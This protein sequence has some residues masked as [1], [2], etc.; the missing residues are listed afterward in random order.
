MYNKFRS[1]IIRNGDLLAWKNDGTVL[2]NLVS[3]ITKG[4]YTHVGIAWTLHNRAYVLDAFW[5]GGVRLRALEDNLPVDIIHT[6]IKW[7]S[8][9]EDSAMSKLGRSYNY[10]NAALLGF[11]ITPNY[12]S[13]VCS[14]YA[15]STLRKGGI[16]IPRDKTVT[17]TPQRL[18]EKV[19][20]LTNAE[21]KT[22][23]NI[24]GL[25]YD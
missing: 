20:E 25:K 14:L 10:L 11:D 17:L 6:K 18:V 3:Y 9:I 7:N 22:I 5:K 24:K 4:V 13:E 2:G 1:N 23:K 21:I 12:D 19:C 8:E 15:A 16:N